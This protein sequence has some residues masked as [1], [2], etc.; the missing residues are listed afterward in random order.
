MDI[1][2]EVILRKIETLA[3]EGDLTRTANELPQDM[4]GEVYDLDENIF[5]E[6]VDHDIS[7]DHFINVSLASFRPSLTAKCK[8]FCSNKIIH[9]LS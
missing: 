9:N 5:V 4:D 6:F 7:A 1:L 2:S 8:R 3:D